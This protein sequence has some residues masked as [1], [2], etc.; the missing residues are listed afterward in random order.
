MYGV[1]TLAGYAH[2]RRDIPD[3]NLAYPVLFVSSVGT[4]TKTGS[5]FYMNTDK[6]IYFV[7]ARH[8]LYLKML[9]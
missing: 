5:G 2:A 1:L 7:T 8:V 4:K 9:S 6:S 3:D